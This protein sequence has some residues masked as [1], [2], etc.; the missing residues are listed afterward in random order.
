MEGQA[1]LIWLF[2]VTFSFSFARDEIEA[3]NY[4][5]TLSLRLSATS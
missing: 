5:L 1:I 4:L 3:G 2:V